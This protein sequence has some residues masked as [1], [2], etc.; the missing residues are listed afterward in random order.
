MTYIADIVELDNCQGD[1]LSKVAVEDVRMTDSDA[2][3]DVT[4]MLEIGLIGLIVADIH[5]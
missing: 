2:G 5:T 3:T 4:E 1:I